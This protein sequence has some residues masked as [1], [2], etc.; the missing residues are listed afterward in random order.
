MVLYNF[1]I[2]LYLGVC[3]SVA[4]HC[5]NSYGSSF[6]IA[7]DKNVGKKMIPMN[8]KI[9]KGTSWDVLLR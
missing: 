2:F 8:I 7:M 3:A 5:S 4:N 9:I 6:I 1:S